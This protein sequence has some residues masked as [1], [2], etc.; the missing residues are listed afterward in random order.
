MVLD[1]Q[2]FYLRS[3]DASEALSEQ[4]DALRMAA[5]A[6]IP[7]AA[8]DQLFG[9]LMTQW[10]PESAPHQ[11]PADVLENLT[12]LAGLCAI[13]LENLRLLEEA[14]HA[15]ERDPLTGVATRT[16]LDRRMAVALTVAG[17]YFT[18]RRVRRH[19]P[20]QGPERSPG[21]SRW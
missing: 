6:V 4:L 8:G 12:G 10:G 16:L 15:S 2:P 14:R 13:A 9:F 20:L 17:G 19:R 11:L 21:A 18:R 5:A 1:L 7:V 3:A